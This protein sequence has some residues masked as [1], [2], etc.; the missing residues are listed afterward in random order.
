[1]EVLQARYGTVCK[2]LAQKVSAYE[3]SDSTALLK[4]VSACQGC[5]ADKGSRSLSLSAGEV[6]DSVN[7]GPSGL[8]LE[9]EPCPE[10]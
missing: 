3:M 7:G 5:L 2:I 1:M 10:D 4:Y 6:S 9:R 8:Y